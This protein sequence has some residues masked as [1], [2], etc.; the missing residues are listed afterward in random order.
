MRAVVKQNWK[1][2]LLLIVLAP[3]LAE[4]ISGSTPLPQFFLP[5][6]FFGYVLSL[7]G[8]QVLSFGRSPSA[9]SWACSGCGAWDWSMACTARACPSPSGSVPGTD[10]FR[11]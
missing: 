8:L 1:P 2:I 9:G 11:W 6:I 4:V 5:G 3:F 7:Y 10:S